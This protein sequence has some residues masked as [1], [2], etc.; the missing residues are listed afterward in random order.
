MTPR[1]SH[2]HDGVWQKPRVPGVYL[3]NYA[4]RVP[5]DPGYCVGT[6]LRAILCHILH[7]GRLKGAR[8]GGYTGRRMGRG[9]WGS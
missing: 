8:Q 9:F 4:Y 5:D 3:F 1:L 6:S 2:A 7:F